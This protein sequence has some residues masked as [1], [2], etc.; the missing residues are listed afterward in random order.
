MKQ[1]LRVA[2]VTGEYPPMEGGVGDF[3]RQLSLA[4]AAQG[5]EVHVVTTA[6]AAAAPHDA[7][8]S[9]HRVVRR[10]GWRGC[11]ALAAQLR[12][13]APDVVNLQYQAAAYGMRGAVNFFPCFFRAAPLVVTFHDLLPPYLF[14]KAGPLRPWAVRRLARCADGVIVTNDEDAGMLRRALAAGH[15]PP[16]RTIPIG[17]NIAP[18]PPPGYDRTAWRIAHGFPPDEL[19]VGFFGFLNRSKGVETLLE[20]VARLRARGIPLHVLFIGGRTGTSDRTNARYADEVDAQIA[21]LGLGA[22]VHRTG[23]TRPAEVSAALMGLDVCAL[24]Y[25]DGVSLRRGTFHAALV[26]GVPIVTT[27]PRV[28]IPQL[29]EGEYVVLVPPD[30]AGALAGAIE[31]LWR[32][33]ARRRLLG[34][35]AAMLA[36]EFSWDR[37]AARTV[38]FFRSLLGR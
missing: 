14:P 4:M 3:S 38:A 32:D 31:A 36:R 30:D 1:G 29:Q 17:S 37:I 10:W 35:N 16:V 5:H 24:P 22:W 21:R 20:A 9:V 2:V 28:P 23:F 15:R 13:L 34:R 6:V 7:A 18:A 19:L 25:R 12:A 27:V 33:P 26:H 11:L 8:L